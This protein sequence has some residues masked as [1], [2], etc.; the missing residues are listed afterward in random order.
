MR[1]T[2]PSNSWTDCFHHCHGVERI[3]EWRTISWARP[4]AKI[5][6][7]PNWSNLKG[8]CAAQEGLFGYCYCYYCCSSYRIRSARR[9]SASTHLAKLSTRLR[10][11]I[12]WARLRYCRRSTRAMFAQFA[13]Y[14]PHR[15][16]R[17]L[18]HHPLLSQQTLP[19][20]GSRPSDLHPSLQ[21][22]FLLLTMKRTDGTIG[23]ACPRN[24]SAANASARNTE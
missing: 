23:V 12:P 15:N 13:G 2:R 22:W 5:W 16:D 19:R 8:K 24:H 21:R 17:P 14:H 4:A 11:C 3:V 18:L 6:T 20:I 7:F 1:P 10:T 9:L